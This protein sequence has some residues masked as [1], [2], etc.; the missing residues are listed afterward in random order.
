MGAPATGRC[1]ISLVYYRNHG[2]NLGRVLAGVQVPEGDDATF[3]EHL[4]E[5]GYA[6]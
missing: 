2:S 5:L 1:N 4:D 6:W 3:H